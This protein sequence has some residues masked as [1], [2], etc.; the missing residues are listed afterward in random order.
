MGSLAEKWYHEGMQLGE[1][2]GIQLGEARGTQRGEYNKAVQTARNLLSENIPI[3]T[4]SKCTGLS[5]AEVNKIK[6]EMGN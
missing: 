4:I 3:F 2:R 6:V 1:A 5:I